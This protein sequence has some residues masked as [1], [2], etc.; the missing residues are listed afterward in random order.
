MLMLFSS[1]IL[2]ADISSAT[3]MSEMGQ[4]VDISTRRKRCVGISSTEQKGTLGGVGWGNHHNA[5][6]TD[7]LL[8]TSA[9]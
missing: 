6:V 8:E 4:T 5:T 2:S 7:W 9:K 3:G 1:I